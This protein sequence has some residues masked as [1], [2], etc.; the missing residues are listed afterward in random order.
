MKQS[1]MRLLLDLLTEI[2]YDLEFYESNK[3]F[4]YGDKILEEK[5]KE[6]LRKVDN[7]IKKIERR[8]EVEIVIRL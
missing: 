8:K 4:F 6:G 2:A 3:D 7:L 1:V 5:I